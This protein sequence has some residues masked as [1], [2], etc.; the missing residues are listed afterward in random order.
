MAIVNRTSAQNGSTRV[1][2][3]EGDGMMRSSS[4]TIPNA[5]DDT[6]ASVFRFGRVPS[7]AT[8]KSVKL[9]NG[10][11]TAGALDIGVHNVLDK[12]AGAAVDADLF[13]SA[14]SIITAAAN[15]EVISESGTVTATN[16]V[17]PLWKLAGLAEDPGGFFDVT[18]TISTTFVA[19]A[20]GLYLDVQYAS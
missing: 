14:V 18:A 1:N 8:I 11:S 17:E 19:A 2:V 13:G 12:S 6:A 15:S 7:N 5:A 16:R 4:A 3:G 9:T 20:V 10:A